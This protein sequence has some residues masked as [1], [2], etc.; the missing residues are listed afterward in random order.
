VSAAARRGLDDLSDAVIEM[1]SADFA[2]AL[3]EVDSSNGKV[4]AYLSAHAEIYRQEYRDNRVMVH[5]Y[6]PR[7][8]F[9]HIMGPGVEV[10]FLDG[11]QE[12]SSEE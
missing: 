10:R 9:H 6:L 11:P 3:V 1:L 5:C 4:L 7:H 8:L 12:Q 2:N